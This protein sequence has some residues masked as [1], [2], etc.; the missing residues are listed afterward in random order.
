M[1]GS[2]AAR[3]ALRA[4]A[5]EESGR[6][7]SSSSAAN[8]SAIVPPGIETTEADIVKQM[9]GQKIMKKT[10]K[11]KMCKKFFQ[12]RPVIVSCLRSLANDG[13]VAA[14]K[15][16][17]DFEAVQ[18]GTE[19]TISRLSAPE[20]GKLLCKIRNAIYILLP[21]SPHHQLLTEAA[22]LAVALLSLYI[23]AGGD[24][25]GATIHSKGEDTYSHSKLTI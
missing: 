13:D 23:N 20:L 19:S 5:R 8:S 22:R 24:S 11:A 15:A 12:L 3:Q 2:G 4:A 9:Q 16:L 17:Q 10:D 1:A 14:G 6:G 18:F 21:T 25:N 7:S